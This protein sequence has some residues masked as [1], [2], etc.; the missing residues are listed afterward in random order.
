M[1]ELPPPAHLPCE[2]CGA[3]VAREARAPHDCDEER[4]LDYL[5]FQERGEVAAFDEALR[6]WL[7]TAQGRFERY[8]ARRSRPAG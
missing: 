8:Y 7:E 4:R 5:L 6:D 2:R 1:L 3:S